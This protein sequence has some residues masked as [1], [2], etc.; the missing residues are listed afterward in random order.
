MMTT[1]WKCEY[2][3]FVLLLQTALVGRLV[4]LL[5]LSE[6]LSPVANRLARIL[7]N[8]SVGSID[9]SEQILKTNCSD[10]RK[11]DPSSL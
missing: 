8:C 2:L 9:Q 6:S 4:S 7:I 5:F 1:K 10:L 11:Y 3:H